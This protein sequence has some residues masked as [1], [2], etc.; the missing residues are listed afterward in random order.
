VND[1]VHPTG[2]LVA[3]LGALTVVSGFVDAVSF[4]GLGHVFVANMT[5]NVVWLG[6]A[7]AGAA[8]FSVSA[9]L[10]AL[11]GFL[12]GAILCGRIA[13][14]VPRHRP[15]MIVVLLIEASLTGVAAIV[16]ASVSVS[17]LQSGS[18]RL[19]VIVL[20]ALGIGA[21][22]SAVRWLKVPEMTTT[23][24][25]TTLTGLAS[26]SALA[27]GMNKDA[28]KGLTSVGSMFLGAIV[29]AVLTIHFHPALP[30]GLAALIVAS[31]ALFYSRQS[32]PE[33]G[34]A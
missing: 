9:S 20:L 16:A 5:G 27:G 13:V 31:T 33:L 3:S 12:C 11:A 25:T 2:S 10:C 7:V 32:A 29:G 8:G 26:E 4:L 24:L 6:F 19:A 28:S 1:Q 30:L 21:R 15:L 22:N 18:P 17:S 23:V 34:I 14:R